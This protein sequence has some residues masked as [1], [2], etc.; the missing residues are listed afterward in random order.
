MKNIIIAL[1]MIERPKNHNTL[2]I[3][4]LIVLFVLIALKITTYFNSAQSLKKN[5]V[6]KFFTHCT[7]ECHT[8]WVKSQSYHCNDFTI[9][10]VG[11]CTLEKLEG[12]L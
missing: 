5:R 6:P 10:G 1:L 4:F 12:K 7:G 11:P 3:M 9:P 2:L 8:R